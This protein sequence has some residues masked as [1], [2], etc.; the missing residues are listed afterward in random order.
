M[1]KNLRLR[2]AADLLSENKTLVSRRIQR[3]IAWTDTQRV[4]YISSLF[5][6]RAETPIM[7]LPIA[8][9]IDYCKERR[10]YYQD[11]LPSEL[12][13]IADYT[14]SIESYEKWLLQGYKF[15]SVDGQNR[16]DTI[17]KLINGELSLKGV[18]FVNDSGKEINITK[19][20][21]FNSNDLEQGIFMYLD[22]MKSVEV[23]I[24]EPRSLEELRDTF[25]NLQAGT[26]LSPM[27]V[28]SAIFSPVGDQ[29]HTLSTKYKDLFTALSNQSCNYSKKEDQ[30]WITKL[31]RIIRN[32]D[33]NTKVK[34][35]EE[36]W[37]NGK[38]LSRKEMN[39]VE[40][41]L[42]LTRDVVL[43][44]DNSN[45]TSSARWKFWSIFMACYWMETHVPTHSVINLK[46]FG[47]LVVTEAELLRAKSDS[48]YGQAVE[49][50][51]KSGKVGKNPTIAN[52]FTHWLGNSDEGSSRKRWFDKMFG[53]NS[54]VLTKLIN[55]NIITSTPS[56]QKQAA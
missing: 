2:Q 42:D 13:K 5:S 17:C 22:L 3:R 19:K 45:D 46:E 27:D 43:S 11:Y 24:L 18:G 1:Y 40:R 16:G 52:Y 37:R 34:T 7:V 26:P 55:S 56:S 8:D 35:H 48:D 12:E 53:A 31:F 51:I 44:M 10:Q 29:V 15:I 38:K 49:A 41:I 20:K 9:S 14:S 36:F 6:N 39:L 21:H 4:D 25:I 28:I 54:T 50:W 30:D 33:S 47:N 23:K 32:H